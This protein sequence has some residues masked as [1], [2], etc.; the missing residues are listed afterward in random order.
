M[1]FSIPVISTLALAATTVA[2]P[3]RRTGSAA[4]IL[5]FQFAGVLERLETEFYTQALQKFQ[6]PDFAAAG[7]GNV[8]VPK[9]IFS[10]ILSDETAHTSIIESTLTSL[11]SAPVSGCKFDFGKALDDVATMA[12]TARVVENVGV[13]AYL[14]GANL[15]ENKEL[16]VAAASI[17]SIEARHQSILNVLNTAT[18]IPQAF[19]IA[20]SPSQV[21]AIA[22]GFISGCDLGIPAL[23][24]LTVTNTG[25]IGPGTSLTFSSDGIPSGVDPSTLTCQMMLGGAPFALALPIEQCVVPENINGPVYIFIVNGTQPLLN[26]QTNQ[27]SASILAG[28]TLAFIDTV[29][30]TLG[31]VVKNAVAEVP[32]STTITPAEATQIV[33]NAAAA[34]PAVAEPVAE[35]ASVSATTD[36]ATTP[37]STAAES[38]NTSTGP[39]GNGAVDVLGWSEPGATASSATP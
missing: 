6:D 12:A 30:E 34:G 33:N 15:L 7:F 29:P 22:G 37:T 38:A 5:V 8:N 11:G 28:P 35:P 36:A 1:I 20:L 24:A 26:S 16:L 14:G 4:D 17:L 3:I 2:A 18:S 9:E 31:Q 10:T 32:S 21:L 39:A 23:P 27:F 19:D 13:S 25:S